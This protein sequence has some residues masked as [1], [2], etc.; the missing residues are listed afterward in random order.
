MSFALYFHQLK[1]LQGRHTPKCWRSSTQ[2]LN[3]AIVIAAC[4][5]MG[6]YK[7]AG[8]TSCLQTGR[9]NDLSVAITEWKRP[10]IPP[11]GCLLLLFGHVHLTL[12]HLTCSGFLSVDPKLC[13]N[14][15]TDTHRLCVSAAR[16]ASQPNIL[17]SDNSK[18]SFTYYAWSL[19]KLFLCIVVYHT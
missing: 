17:R 8:L 2:Q 3:T 13:R 10:R 6:G 7:G 16:G 14:Q 12:K 19:L 9:W 4:W 11:V 18:A 1:P 15:M 5:E